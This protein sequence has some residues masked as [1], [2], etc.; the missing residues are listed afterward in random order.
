MLHETDARAHRVGRVLLRA[1]LIGAGIVIVLAAA[2]PSLIPS[3]RIARAV[4]ESVERS[5][6][7][8]VHVGRC[9]LGWFSGLTIEELRID[10][11]PDRPGSPL[12]RIEG[13]SLDYPPW[14]LPRVLFSSS[15]ILGHATIQ[16]L[17]T[18]VRRDE[19]GRL[20]L[21]ESTGPPPEFKS[22]EVLRGD[23]LM[24]LE[25]DVRRM[26]T[27]LR[28]KLGRLQ[29]SDKAYLTA[30][31]R[32]LLADEGGETGFG[33]VSLNGL[34]DHFDLNNFAGI[35]GGG[36]LEWQGV[37]A[38]YFLPQPPSLSGQ[39]MPL[40]ATTSGQV[41]V[42]IDASDE[43]TFQGSLQ[44]PALRMGK[45]G[46]D[47]RVQVDRPAL[48]FVGRFNK[49]T[50]RARLEPVQVSG[51]GSSLRVS[52]D[53]LLERDGRLD[54]RLDLDGTLGW[55]PL[56]HDVSVL[57]RSLEGFTS[58]TGTA[59]FD[60]VAL[61]FGGTLSDPLLTLNGAVS[62][63]KTELVLEPWFRK[64]N[65]LP[66]RLVLEGVCLRPVSR[67]VS[68]EKIS[69]LM[70]PAVAS[71]AD[72]SARSGVAVTATTAPA[73]GGRE[74]GHE[75]A[76]PKDRALQV[77][78]SIPE[79]QRLSRYVPAA[80]AL[81]EQYDLAGGLSLRGTLDLGS[82]PWPVE[83]V[84]DAGGLALHTGPGA[85]KERGVPLAL[86]MEGMCEGSG[87]L[88][89]WTAVSLVLGES[90]VTW[91]G[92]LALRRPGEGSGPR[93]EFEGDV[94]ARGIQEWF[95][96]LRPYL[97][98]RPDFEAVGNILCRIN[99]RVSEEAM[100]VEARRIDATR[101][102]LEIGCPGGE[103][104]RYLAK[105]LGRPAEAQYAVASYEKASRRLELE[106]K[107][108]IADTTME[109]R[110]R[111]DRLPR[112][113]DLREGVLPRAA[114]V[115]ADVQCEDVRALLEY[116]PAVQE[117]LKPFAPAG[118]MRLSLGGELTEQVR[119][120]A[121]A[122]LTRTTWTVPGEIHKTEELPLSLAAEVEFPAAI[123][124]GGL[125]CH[126]RALTVRAGDCRVAA[127]GRVTLNAEALGGSL[128]GTLPRALRSAEATMSI[129]LVQDDRLREFSRWWRELS[130]RYGIEGR[131]EAEVSVSGTPG[132]GAL[133]LAVEATE[134]GF[135]Y[136]E[137]TEKPPGVDSRLELSIG[138]TT[139]AGELALHRAALDIAGTHA[140]AEGTLYRGGAPAWDLRERLDFALRL[141][142]RSN[143]LARLAQLVPVGAL[144][145]CRPRGGMVFALDVARDRH[146][147][148]LRSGEFEFDQARFRLG[149]TDLSAD[150]TLHVGEERL[151]ANEL[152][153]KIDGA[154]VVATGEI[155]SPRRAPTGEFVVRGERVDLDR[156]RRALGQPG[157]DRS[158][159]TGVPAGWPALARFLKK[160]DVHGRLAFDR[161]LWSDATGIRYDWRAF[162]SEL[163]LSNGRLTVPHFKAVMLGGVVIGRV[164]AD[165]SETNPLVKTEYATRN[166]SGAEDLAPMIHR[167]FPDMTVHGRADQ[168]HEAEAPLF[169]V[170]ERS[171]YPEGVSEFEAT[172]GILEGPAAP[173]WLTDL[174]PGLK[175]A[176]YRFGRMRSITR[177][178]P[179]GRSVSD[180]FF[181]GSP[182]SIHIAGYTEADGT[183]EYTLSID[184][185]GGVE[186]EASDEPG[187]GGRIPFL[188]YTGRL[189]ESEW[190]E[191]TVRFKLPHEVAWHVFVRRDPLRELLEETGELRRPNFEPYDFEKRSEEVSAPSG[192]N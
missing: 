157:D 62:L 111:I 128:P 148:E 107:G 156:L 53:L 117:R 77:A 4:E 116:L 105:P 184:L 23:I 17:T 84:L 85:R 54:G 131:A 5:F 73:E 126:L 183:A 150:G 82:P 66:A 166:L 92:S 1:G 70:G 68:V 163:K 185:F 83:V 190:E 176:T 15:P 173:D 153:V 56:R 48:S 22:L 34:L 49:S 20:D 145:R 8:P 79:V 134:A 106:M 151:S 175:L 139:S 161:F 43:I 100:F 119:L 192:E 80:K 154:N 14:E 9:D 30:G 160:V 158:P 7:R 6:Q 108:S 25:S 104:L 69:L 189:R 159:A 86:T 115:Q 81:V 11:G 71:G 187:R 93:L 164:R 58:A 28:L 50:G 135:R 97:P 101:A 90:R 141:E 140:E 40:R 129:R 114:T 124:P 35:T 78:V 63:D 74:P 172:E 12:L 162:S 3:S 102:S 41:S 127:R 88:P 182:Y 32:L 42:R 118:P 67:H 75:E 169:A 29:G 122:D 55:T 125:R 95:G 60:G 132:D 91:S 39:W 72:E 174:L 165:L 51:A 191:R 113:A 16:T 168:T 133:R 123:E 170:G 27:R 33:S 146:G 167:L 19:Q 143:E 65:G 24:E 52:G 64:P 178:Q 155:H 142:G 76:G 18:W 44:A 61:D 45:P 96:L 2:G 26:V 36:A 46:A 138:T 181:D 177:M 130:R 47:P 137:G 59:D 152:A 121:E 109:T 99:G 89:E 98:R 110:A 103:G 179:D 57:G 149:G 21:V 188:V 37:G 186:G 112:A 147:L 180:M 136:G 144:Q 94:D 38:E 87:A 171:N 10:A 120:R 13:M 31:A